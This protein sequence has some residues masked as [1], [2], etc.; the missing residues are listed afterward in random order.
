VKPYLLFHPDILTHFFR[1]FRYFLAAAPEG[2]ALQ[3]PAEVWAKEARELWTGNA[4]PQTYVNY[5]S[6]RCYESLESVYGYE[7]WRLDR[8]RELK[9]KY[10]PHNNF[11]YYEPIIT[12][13]TIPGN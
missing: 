11:R 8:L 13:K 3:E 6:G 4:K 5:A 1:L 7:P 10:D 12:N 9:A 2:S